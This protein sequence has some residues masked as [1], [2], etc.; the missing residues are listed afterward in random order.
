MRRSLLGE[1]IEEDTLA[2]IVNQM[3]SLG[4]RLE[5]EKEDLHQQEERLSYLEEYWEALEKDYVWR[6]KSNPV[7]VRPSLWTRRA[8]GIPK[9][10]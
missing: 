7:D 1:E 9:R 6:G 10:K 3:V 4:K 2:G 5:E 8:G